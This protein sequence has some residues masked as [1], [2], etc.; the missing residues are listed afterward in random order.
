MRYFFLS[1]RRAE[2]STHI[3][4]EQLAHPKKEKKK[5][6]TK[7]KHKKKRK[8]VKLLMQAPP[9]DP[10]TMPAIRM[11]AQSTLA[12]VREKNRGSRIDQKPL[13][14]CLDPKLHECRSKKKGGGINRHKKNM[15]VDTAARK[16][17]FE[18]KKNIYLVR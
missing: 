8:K 18:K 12:Q 6:T 9:T 4:S 14:G 3:I 11:K 16:T 15:A 17:T 13:V 1:P 5:N 2:E 10:R 7:Q